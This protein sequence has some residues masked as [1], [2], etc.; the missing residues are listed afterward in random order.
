MNTLNMIVNS[1]VVD[2]QSSAVKTLES[3]GY[4]TDEAI[5]VVIDSDHS[6]D[7]VQDVID[8]PVETAIAAN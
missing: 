8:N 5:K 7:L 6:F 2:T 4:T 1:F 3:L